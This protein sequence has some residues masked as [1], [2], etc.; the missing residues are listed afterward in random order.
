MIS[1]WVVLGTRL[2]TPGN[3]LVEGGEMRLRLAYSLIHWD[4]SP[5]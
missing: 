2:G 3:E 4:H 5:A 1:A